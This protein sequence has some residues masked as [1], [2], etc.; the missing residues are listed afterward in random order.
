MRRARDIEFNTPGSVV[1]LDFGDRNFDTP[2][3]IQPAK[4][5][6]TFWHRAYEVALDDLAALVAPSRVVICEGEMGKNSVDA[7][8]YE[9]I[10]K[11]E[12]PDTR[13]APMGSA[14]EIEDDKR[15]LAEALRLVIGGL[16]VVRLI[17]RDDRTHIEIADL[18]AKGIRVL[19][20]R[21]LESY[22]FDNEVLRAL[23]VSTDKKE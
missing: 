20:R 11:D 5:D 6:R 2:Q 21:N 14:R 13:F 22:L 1:F 16:V 10:F 12:F 17:D 9:Q 15:G 19:S 23:A 7:P 18:A 8:C 4:P 3:I